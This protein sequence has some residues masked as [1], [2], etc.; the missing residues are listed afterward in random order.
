M[1]QSGLME[2]GINGTSLS[3]DLSSKCYT[4]YK[5]L[6]TVPVYYNK[7]YYIAAVPSVHY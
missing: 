5:K 6:P 7:H 1:K 3:N 2:Q 4:Q